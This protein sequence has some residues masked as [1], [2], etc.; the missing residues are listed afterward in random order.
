MVRPR[1]LEVSLF[2]PSHSTYN[3]TSIAGLVHVF[4]LDLTTLIMI[5]PYQ[6]CLVYHTKPKVQQSHKNVPE[7][8][9]GTTLNL[10]NTKI[11]QIVSEGQ[12]SLHD[13]WIIEPF[14][15]ESKNHY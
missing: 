1:E 7:C 11:G 3:S 14:K 9:N 5:F 10:Y 15:R 12:S 13:Y 6:T 8:L 4:D 2:L